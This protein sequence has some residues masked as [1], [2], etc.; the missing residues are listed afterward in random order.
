MKRSINKDLNK[1]ALAFFNNLQYDRY[2]EF[3]GIGLDDK[4]PFGNSY[5]EGDILDIID[6]RNEDS[7]TDEQK[8]Y[9]RELYYE[10]LIPYLKRNCMK[11]F[12]K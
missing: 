4:R 10:R 8:E 7:D 3:G 1:L 5:V 9:A 6:W 11:L 12:R 2:G